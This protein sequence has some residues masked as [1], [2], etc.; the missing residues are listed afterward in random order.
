MHV[1]I[2]TNNHPNQLSPLKH[3]KAFISPWPY[4]KKYIRCCL[5][6]YFFAE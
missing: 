2:N 4:L 6:L 3:L 5:C 1:I